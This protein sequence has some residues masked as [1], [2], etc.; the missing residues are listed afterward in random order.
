MGHT[1]MYNFNSIHL[2]YF[3]LIVINTFSAAKFA[4]HHRYNLP[5]IDDYRLFHR[6]QSIAQIA[7]SVDCWIVVK[8]DAQ[9]GPPEKYIKLAQ[10]YTGPVLFGLMKSY[11]SHW[12]MN[13]KA[14]AY[15]FP[16]GGRRIKQ[17]KMMPY[18]DENQLV[19]MG[20][21]Q[22][23]ELDLENLEFILN[24]AYAK[25]PVRFP[26]VITVPDFVDYEVADSSYQIMATAKVLSKML[27]RFFD[28]NIVMEI[29]KEEFESVA[30]VKA[31]YPEVIVL[32]GRLNDET[33]RMKF[34]ALR[35][36]P[37]T[38]FNWYNVINWLFTMNEDERINLVGDN[39]AGD[40]HV[41]MMT[42]VATYLRDRLQVAQ[43]KDEL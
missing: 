15:L 19:W 27:E 26:A 20:L 41:Q 3:I 33:Q 1:I 9:G 25:S 16:Y 39:K 8:E 13:D 4:S 14:E 28:V 5:V 37:E 11:N 7:Y 2:C 43:L 30:G 17:T 35:M 40:K 42:E 22:I 18:K 38:E 31:R 12:G 36:D 24:N 6:L 32:L 21:P 10:K 29:D 34:D 23:T